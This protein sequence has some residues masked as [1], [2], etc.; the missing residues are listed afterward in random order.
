MDWTVKFFNW[1]QGIWLIPT[2]TQVKD[3]FVHATALK[4]AAELETR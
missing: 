2:T 4:T 3:I 1:I